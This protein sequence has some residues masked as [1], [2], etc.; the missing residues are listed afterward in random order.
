MLGSCFRVN[1]HRS[2]Y[3]FKMY[4]IVLTASSQSW[5]TVW[6]RLFLLFESF[7]LPGTHWLLFFHLHSNHARRGGAVTT[8]NHNL[9]NEGMFWC[10]CTP[11]LLGHLKIRKLCCLWPSASVKS[12]EFLHLMSSQGHHHIWPSGIWLVWLHKPSVSILF[13]K[14]CSRVIW[15][16]GDHFGELTR[17]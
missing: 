7:L 12:W 4:W 15:P 3:I 5:V 10:T 8:S 6:S 14:L 11:T 2:H 9:C 16:F 13:N 1:Q 17:H